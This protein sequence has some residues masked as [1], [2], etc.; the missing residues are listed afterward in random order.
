MILSL[1]AVKAL[2][3]EGT[4]DVEELLDAQAE[5]LEKRMESLRKA[6]SLSK[7]EQKKQKRAIAFLHRA[8][9]Q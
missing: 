7:T 5:R 6:N 2:A 4:T 3:A 8:Q 9:K 1:R